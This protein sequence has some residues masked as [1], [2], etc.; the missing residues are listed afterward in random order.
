M[1]L[2]GLCNCDFHHGECNDDNACVKNALL[3]ENGICEC[4][5]GFI[6]KQN[7]CVALE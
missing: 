4:Q 7:E 1:K 2:L 6:Q 5:L 3:D